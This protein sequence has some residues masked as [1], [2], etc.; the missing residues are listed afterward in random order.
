MGLCVAWVNLQRSEVLADGLLGLS[1]FGEGV[2]K[3]IMGRRVFEP[4]LDGFAVFSDGSLQVVL[5]I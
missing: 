1:I 4:K 2:T 3:V 5:G